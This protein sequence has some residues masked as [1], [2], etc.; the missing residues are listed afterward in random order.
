MN[1]RHLEVFHAVMQAGSVTGAAHLLNVTQPAVSNVLRHAEQQLKFKLF[2]RIAG[3]LQPTPEA[4]ELFPDVQEIF[5]RID[6]LNRSVDEIRGGRAGRL[7]IAASPTFVNAYL[8]K[9]VSRLHEHSPGARVTIH[10]LPTAR[11]IEERVARRA[12]DIG[13]VYAPVQDPSVVVEQ[14]TTSSVVCAVPRKS[15]LAKRKELGPE[16]L[17]SASVVTTGPTTRIGTAI[18]EIYDANGLSMPEVAV[19]LNSSQAVC[20]MVAEGVGIGLVDLATV[21][22]YPLPDV[23][24]CPFRPHIELSL[25]LI[26]PRDRP[27][28]R[29]AVRLAEGLRAQFLSEPRCVR[30]AGPASTRFSRQ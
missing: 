17:A 20:L 24:F 15:P 22:Q 5:G 2:E 19:E 10:A 27:R 21:L 14:V 3:R 26:Y 28:S 16:D 18:Q 8:P 11:T 1:L 29:L 13:L 9:A 30:R 23:V 4:A 12:V 7:A 6:T 25:C